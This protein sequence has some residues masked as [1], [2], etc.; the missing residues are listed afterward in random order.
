MR[1]ATMDLDLEV[2]QGPFDL[3]LTL[4]L[5]EEVDLLEVDL[6]DVVRGPGKAG[7][8][9]LI[10]IQAVLRGTGPEEVEREF[11]G[12]GY[13]DFKGAVAETVVAQ[14]GPIRDRYEELAADPAGL[15]AVLRDGAERARAIAADT[16]AEVRARMGV[17]AAV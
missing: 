5:N 9:N 17:G 2:F 1:A 13:G 15:E 10:E 8:A 6:A 16:M 4:V 12:S 11:A 7:I 3:L 14:L